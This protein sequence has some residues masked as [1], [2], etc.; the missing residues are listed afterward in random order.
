MAKFKPCNED[1]L[2]MLPISLQNQFVPGTLDT[3][4]ANWWKNISTCRS[5]MRATTTTKLVQ[6]PSIPR[7]CGE[8][9]LFL[10]KVRI[11]IPAVLALA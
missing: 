10:G 7:F 4:S 1:Q 6:P 8:V 11:P 9:F 3:P 2:V 5:L